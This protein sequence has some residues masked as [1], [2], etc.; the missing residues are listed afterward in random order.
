MSSAFSVK[1]IQQF[2]LNSEHVMVIPNM[3]M[4]IK[5]YRS[6]RSTI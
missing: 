2:T 1:N 6:E 4:G 3:N 5:H